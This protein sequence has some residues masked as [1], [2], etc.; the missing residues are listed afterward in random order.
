MREYKFVSY[1]ML[2]EKETQQNKKEKEKETEGRWK[3]V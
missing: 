1:A 3:Y 2:L